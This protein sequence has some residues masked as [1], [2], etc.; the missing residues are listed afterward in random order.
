MDG[1]RIERDSLGEVRVPSFAYWGAQTQ[2]AIENFPVSGIR[3]PR[4]F[5]RSLG[6]LK[7]ACAEVNLTGGLLGK[8]TANAIIRA[9]SEVAEGRLDDHFP[10]DI[11]QTGSG[12]STNMNAN[13]VIA[14]RANEILTG[15]RNAK[16]P[17]H[18]NDHVN[19]GQSSNDIIPSAINLAATLQVREVLLPALHTLHDAISRRSREL[20]PVVKTG[21]THLMDAMPL[22]LGQE[23]SGWAAQVRHGIERVSGALPRLACLAV[24]GTAVGTGVNTGP[25]FGKKVAAVVSRMTGMDFREAEN[26]FEAQAAMDAVAELSGQVKTVATSLMKISNDL[27][28]MNSGPVAGLAEIRLPALQP[29]SSIM[30]GKVNPV[31]PEAVRMVCAQVI[32]ND[33]VIAIANSLGEFELN[34]MLPVICRNVV[35]SVTI[36]GNAA[37]L[38]AEKAVAGFEADEAKI[39]D[40]LGKNPILA[41]VLNPAI[42]YDRAA[43]VVKKAFRERRTVQEVVVELGYLSAEEAKKVLDPAVMTRPGFAG[44]KEG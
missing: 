44:G 25:D 13:E 42:G 37:R 35:E 14:D 16:A 31:I 11:F 29:G 19:L 21:R 24:G 23:L 33:T 18:P 41:T 17:V 28:L 20:D 32:G 15:T 26:H 2:R 7:S 3:F 30:P 6:I 1:F 34:V 43:E 10:L 12:T 4:V 5:I 22:T 8:D 40:L 38:L 27:R 9:A 36:L 39:A